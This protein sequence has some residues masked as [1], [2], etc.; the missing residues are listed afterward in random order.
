MNEPR[1]GAE[2]LLELVVG[3]IPGKPEGLVWVHGTTDRI[4]ELHITIGHI[5]CDIIDQ[6]YIDSAD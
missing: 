2:G 3:T 4:Q 6:A 1:P 5:L